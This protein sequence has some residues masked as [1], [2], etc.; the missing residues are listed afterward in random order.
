MMTSAQMKALA[1]SLPPEVRNQLAALPPDQ[2][3]AALQSIA[4]KMRKGAPKNKSGRPKGRGVNKR[5]ARASEPAPPRGPGR[6][7]GPMMVGPEGTAEG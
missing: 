2:Q 4:E 1:A 3:A 7:M 5:A 6:G